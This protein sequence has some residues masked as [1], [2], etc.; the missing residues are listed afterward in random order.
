MLLVSVVACVLHHVSGL[1]MDRP[2][3]N[4]LQLHLA[5]GAFAWFALHDFGVHRADVHSFEAGRFGH[6]VRPQADVNRRRREHLRLETPLR[7]LDVHTDADR[8]RRVVQERIDEHDRTGKRLTGKRFQLHL[9][10]LPKADPRDIEFIDVEVQ[11]NRIEVRDAI[12]LIA[13]ADV[14]PRADVLFDDRPADRCEDRQVRVRLLVRFQFGDL[15]VEDAQ[16]PQLRAGRFQPRLR[17]A[18]H[19]RRGRLFLLG[20]FERQQQFVLRDVQLGAVNLDEMVSLLDFDA[21]EV[22]EQPIDA[23]VDARRQ[24]RHLPLA[25]VELADRAN[26]LEQFA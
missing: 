15:L 23:A 25:V 19:R 10:R 12:N 5:N 11:P 14:L 8:A 2:L 9:D 7:I 26:L 22:H 20:R 17:E 18:L 6:A 3:W 24:I 21:G 16:Q 1:N 13:G 4:L